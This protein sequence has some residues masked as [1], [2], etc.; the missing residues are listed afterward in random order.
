MDLE[1]IE[2]IGKLN[3][4]TSYGQNALQHSIEVANLCGLMASELGE[5]ITLAKRAGLLHDI[6]KAIDFEVE[7][8][9]VDLGVE[10]AKKHHESDE[11]INAIASHHGNTDAK[12]T[13]AVLVEIA[14]TLSAARP[15][16]RNDSLENYIKRLEQLE[17]IGNSYD[18]VE[19][20]YAM[21]AGRELRVIVK[22]DEVDDK[23]SYKM[24]RDIKEKIESEMQYPGTIKIT[25]IRET[26]VQEEAK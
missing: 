23:N 18:G 26:R 16:A 2:L 6:G 4:R 25:V 12:Y 21:Q 7:G 15:G 14:D 22:P 19:K 17:E 8:S 11:V 24:A 9:H 3:Y 10:L 1:L 5:N 20:T 13:I